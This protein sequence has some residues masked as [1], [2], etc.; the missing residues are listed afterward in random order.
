MSDWIVKS[1]GVISQVYPYQ[2]GD[3][4]ITRSQNRDVCGLP[5]KD[6]NPNLFDQVTEENADEAWHEMMEGV[7]LTHDDFQTTVPPVT[8]KPKESKGSKVWFFQVELQSTKIG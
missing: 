3:E 1:T 4:D 8:E 6:F 7:K 2:C 5:K